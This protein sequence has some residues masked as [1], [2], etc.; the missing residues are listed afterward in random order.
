MNVLG[1]GN[2]K[3]Q[4]KEWAKSAEERGELLRPLQRVHMIPHARTY[5]PI[6]Q[7]NRNVE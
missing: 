1:S 3:Q 4:E 5:P 2:N 7:S 6:N